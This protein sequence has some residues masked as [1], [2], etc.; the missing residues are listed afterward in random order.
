MQEWLKQ[1]QKLEIGRKRKIVHCGRTPSM[2]IENG[3]KGWRSYCHRCKESNFYPR[4]QLLSLAEAAEV[5]RGIARR[6]HN[7]LHTVQLP[8]DFQTTHNEKSLISTLAMT[9][10][11]KGGITHSLRMN[12][13]LGYSEQLKKA[14]LPIY[15]M[16]QLVGIVYRDLVGIGPKYII[17]HIHPDRATYTVTPTSI[18]SVKSNDGSIGAIDCQYDCIIVEDALSAMRVGQFLPSGSLLGTS[19]GAGKL[20]SIL[21]LSGKSK[22]RVGL[23]LDPDNAGYVGMQKLGR[24][25][26]L[27]GVEY[28]EIHSSKDPKNLSDHEIVRRIT[29]DRCNLIADYEV[30]G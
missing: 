1:A 25:L 24:S 20:E 10:L 16:N 8:S 2:T 27:M 26:K 15:K 30:P 7:S 21:S 4:E 19:I 14:I 23:W 6:L 13:N 22:P 17:Q 29:G 11:A 5:N 18:V 3:L 28:G 9:W 12:Y